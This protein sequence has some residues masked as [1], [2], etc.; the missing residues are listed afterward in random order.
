MSNSIRDTRFERLTVAERDA[1]RLVR[2]LADMH[3]AD[4]SLFHGVM[5]LANGLQQACQ[6]AK[7]LDQEEEQAEVPWIKR[8]EE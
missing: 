1:V 8:K 4:L 6:I 2:L 7:R 5:S 3:D